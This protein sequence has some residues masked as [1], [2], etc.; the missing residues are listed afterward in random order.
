M[1]CVGER[2][3]RTIPVRTIPVGDVARKRAVTVVGHRDRSLGGGIGIGVA[4]G[5]FIAFADGIVICFAHVGQAVLNGPE[6]HRAVGAIARGHHSV[7][8]SVVHHVK[9]ELLGLEL[10][11]FE[12]LL[13]LEVRLAGRVIRI[14]EA[15]GG[16]AF[17]AG[18]NRARSARGI[19]LLEARGLGLGHL[20][21]GLGGNTRDGRRLA[22]AQL[23]GVAVAHLARGDLRVCRIGHRVGEHAALGLALGGGQRQ[24]ERELLLC[25]HVRGALYGLADLERTVRVVRV[26]YIR[27]G[28]ARHVALIVGILAYLV[29]NLYAMVAILGQTTEA[30]VPIARVRG[31]D[32]LALDQLTIGVEVELD[33]LGALACGVVGVVPNLAAGDLDRLD[34]MLVGDRKP[35]TSIGG[36]HAHVGQIALGRL[37]LDAV[38]D[39]ITLVIEN[40]QSIIRPKTCLPIVSITQHGALARV[41]P[42]GVQMHRHALGALAVPVIA[43]GPSL[44]YRDAK[45][46]ETNLGVVFADHLVGRLHA[47]VTDCRAAQ[48][49]VVVGMGAAGETGLALPLCQV[50]IE[51]LAVRGGILLKVLDL[52]CPHANRKRRRIALVHHKVAA[53]GLFGGVH[54]NRGHVIEAPLIRF[55][56]RPDGTILKVGLSLLALG[57]E[58]KLVCRHRRIIHM[59]IGTR[60]LES[61]HVHTQQVALPH[62]IACIGLVSLDGLAR[63]VER[64]D[65]IE[66]ANVLG[67]RVVRVIERDA[68][69]VYAVLKDVASTVLVEARAPRT[70]VVGID[71]L[72]ELRHRPRQVV[73]LDRYA[74]IYERRVIALGIK[75][76]HGILDALDRILGRLVVARKRIVGL[77]LVAGDGTPAGFRA[78]VG[79]VVDERGSIVA[80][81][82][83]RVDGVERQRDFIAVAVVGL[84]T[85]APAAAILRIGGNARFH[86]HER[87]PGAFIVALEAHALHR[88]VA[89]E[90]DGAKLGLN[91][92]GQQIVEGTGRIWRKDARRRGLVVVGKGREVCLLVHIGRVVERGRLTVL[93]GIVFHALVHAD[94]GSRACQVI[95]STLGATF[96]DE[97]AV[98]VVV[99]RL[100]SV[101]QDRLGRIGVLKELV[102]ACTD[103]LRGLKAHVGVHDI[104]DARRLGAQAGLDIGHAGVLGEQ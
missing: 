64:I 62:D 11:S 68:I 42:I 18:T 40:A 56:R 63:R 95:V 39:G 35:I 28:N 102:H 49:G 23:N 81:G 92:L 37:F 65:C 61:A 45:R 69:A 73:E 33:L 90:L 93:V 84:V 59:R 6:A 41:L 104:G 30:V 88:V 27:A 94:A 79:N 55:R 97:V 32:G 7:A 38:G 10:A 86:R 58:C 34:P 52:G 9:R 82:V 77:A 103:A 67:T 4:L 1:V 20:V 71:L 76:G 96:H 46:L 29:C 15:R 91:A 78:F 72:V 70:L 85:G 25:A 44:L 57:I 17:L 24:L 26:G 53:V 8:V 83:E 14:G 47:H 54:G 36:I 21:G 87:T 75:V 66:E 3:R 31:F 99:V 43:V 98:E 22:A 12:H 48:D 13:G 60:T 19:S 74:G 100:G 5:S 50:G 2:R 89:I 16:G 101:A 51:P 80:L